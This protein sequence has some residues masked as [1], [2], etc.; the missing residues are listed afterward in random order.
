[1]D[2]CKGKNLFTIINKLKYNKRFLSER[3]VKFVIRSLIGAVK[4]L[5]ANNIIHRDIKAENVMCIT[6]EMADGV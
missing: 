4:A 3:R 1:M 2:R 6:E 5:H